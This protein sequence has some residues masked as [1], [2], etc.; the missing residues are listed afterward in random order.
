MTIYLCHDD[1]RREAVR[2]QV[3]L[4][5]I[6]YVEVVDKDAPVFADRQRILR[7]FFVNDPAP[8]GIAA[9]NVRILGGDRVR[10]V[11]V[12][13]V[14]YDGNV[15][16][17][18]V[19][20]A[21]DFSE[22]TLR[23]VETNGDAPLSG[24]DPLLADI[25][26]SF[27]VE[28]PSDFD[29]R[30]DDD[31]PPAVSDAPPIDY[32]AKDYAS[33]RRLM[34]D[35]M[36]FVIPEWKDRNAADLGITLV[37]LLAYVGDRLSYQQDAI[38]TEAYLGTAR[39]RTSVRRHARLVDY[40]MHDGRNARAWVQVKVSADGVLIPEGTELFT[41]LIDMPAAIPPGSPTHRR[42]LEQHPETFRTMHD[43]HLFRAHVDMPFHSWGGVDCCLEKG[44]T[45]ATLRGAYPDL[46]T[47]DVL[48]L[49]ETRGRATGSPVDRDP[50]R[51][52]A[53]RLTRVAKG[54][55]PLGGAFD[56]PP[57]SAPIDVTEIGWAEDDA[58][59]FALRIS[60]T[61]H[62]AGKS[63]LVSCAVAGGNIVL[64]DHGRTVREELRVPAAPVLPHAHTGDAPRAPHAL[65]F[66]PRLKEGPVTQV[67][68][69]VDA[70]APAASAFRGALEAVLPAITLA[71]L[72]PNALDWSARRDLIGS[73][74]LE[75]HFVAEVEDDGRATL[76]FGDGSYGL[77]PEPDTQFAVTYRVGNGQRGNVGIGAIAHLVTTESA[78]V[79][80]R[81]PLPASGGVEAET[82]EHVRQTA[83]FAFRT[84]ERAVTPE[85][86]AERL[87]RRADV[88][89]A[90]ATFR[91]TGS[92]H[93]VFGTIDRHGGRDVEDAYRR[94]LRAYLETYRVVGRDVEVDAPR[95]VPLAIEARV[96]VEREYFRSDVEKVLRAIFSARA[97][98]NGE[99]GLF[100][101]DRFTFGQTVYLSQLYAAAQSVDGVDSVEF[102]IFE[103]QGVPSSS[104]LTS[105]KLTMGR[106]EI[107]RV[108]NDRDYPERGLF[109]LIVVGGK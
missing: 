51:R 62:D 13:S 73:N 105:G 5:G 30:R 74:E 72:P 66:A 7:V 38:A 100:H 16:V 96:C 59:P 27:K 81:N 75:P 29:C 43:V 42:A 35:R 70:S 41:S 23:L 77:R 57:T 58:L 109:H 32:L 107:P 44:A 71:S 10:D 53:V 61:V 86:Y 89:S 31:C 3:A 39:R 2:R 46:R 22:Y 52:H 21:G 92:W 87:E 99:T 68:S 54:S 90:A 82:I 93:T 67:A 18:R 83:P 15:L 102:T 28:C 37:E 20:R 56:D 24:L 97:L 98:P 6:D 104:G 49:E 101:A 19:D 12:E 103:R 108:D 63:A 50:T 47:G 45:K 64:V 34:L 4:N 11:R 9:S 26:F 69:P 85:D 80:V 40:A 78:I 17:V 1:R 94:E 8:A 76:R 91:W 60:E 48:V 25:G 95:L 79:S 88:Q 106:L 84:Q 55:D 33:F 36:A 14:A 65:R